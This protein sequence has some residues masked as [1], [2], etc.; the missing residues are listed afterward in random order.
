MEWKSPNYR[1]GSFQNLSPTEVMAKDASYF[2]ILR[3]FFNKPKDV[4]PPRPLPAVKTDLNA[5]PATGTQMVWFGH[6]SYLLR[7]NGLNILVDPV[8][9][10]YASP[11]SFM[12]KAF[13]GANTYSVADMPEIDILIVTHNHYDHLD[14]GTLRQL[15]SKVKAVYTPLGVGKDL[16]RCGISSSLIT[17]MDWWEEEAPHPGYTLTATPA[18]HFSGRGLK[19]GGSLWASF[20]LQTPDRR[21]YIGGDSGYDSHF[22]KIGEKFGPFDLAMLESGQ[23]NTSWPHIHM[24]PAEA[25]TA[26]GD[27]GAGVLV[28]VHWGKFALAN[29]PWNEPPAGI[30]AAAQ[31]QGRQ[32]ILPRIGELVELGKPFQQQ[33][34]WEEV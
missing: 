24:N 17:E 9:S 25:V 23:Y 21:I 16:V 3:D 34:W 7:N 20:V 13:A 15:H 11:F 32:V 18:R 14:A 4:T 5:L 30:I 19:R 29:H 26:A 31:E 27:L 28:P 22:K 1:K 12:V 6:S 33:H 2:S 8:F 10:G